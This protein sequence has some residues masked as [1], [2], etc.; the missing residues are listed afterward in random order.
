[1]VTSNPFSARPDLRI[2]VSE[3]A[4]SWYDA[5]AQRLI[6]GIDTDL[7]SDSDVALE[8]VR[9]VILP[10]AGY[11]YSGAIAA[12]GAA[13]LRCL[14]PH[15]VI[16]LGPAHRM[17]LTQRMAL[18]DADAF[19]TPLGRVPVD[20]DA[21]QALNTA[22]SCECC[23]TAF[24]GEHSVEIQLPILQRALADFKIVPIIVGRLDREATA[25]LARSLLTI[26]DRHTAV[27]VSS[28]FTHYGTGFGYRPFRDNIEANIRKLDDGA[29][30]EIMRRDPAGFQAYCERSGATICG[31]DPIAVLLSMLPA[32]AGVHRLAYAT[33]GEL[34]GD[35]SHSVSYLAAAFML[36][37]GW[38][39][40]AADTVAGYAGLT[41][42]E[43]QSLLALARQTLEHTLRNGR[44][45]RTTDL[46][47]T[48]S[49]GLC[50]NRGAFVSLHLPGHRLRGCI[51]EILPRRPLYT[52]VADLAVQAALHDPRFAALTLDELPGVAIEI[53]ALTAPHPIASVKEIILG[54][55]GIVIEKGARAAV[56]LPQVASEQGW[57]LAE[58]LGRLSLKAGLAANAWRHEASFSVF[59]AEV[60]S[61]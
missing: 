6:S 57:T 43:K 41:P 39:R 16:I 46:K 59:E 23:P 29:F 33:S 7:Q 61:E 1:M 31:R 4:G 53:S 40:V 22:P 17:A 2:K 20:R 47:I 48:P 11:R 32:D 15:R 55:H 26:T 54:R 25:S 58:T 24:D 45:P 56:F 18:T 35:F 49:A 13:A 52:A 37:S 9:A 10:H 38:P 42:A 36:P 44:P 50:A 8:A 30:A 51:G 27:V 5:D 34:T 12:R 28:D 21:I 60:F 3:L 19:E 14:Q